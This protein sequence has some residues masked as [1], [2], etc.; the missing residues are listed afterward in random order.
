MRTADGEPNSLNQQNFLSKYRIGVVQKEDH[1]GAI[2]EED[3]KDRMKTRVLALI[4]EEKEVR[5][6]MQRFKQMEELEK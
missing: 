3:R 5:E 1:I 6:R 2:H 4:R